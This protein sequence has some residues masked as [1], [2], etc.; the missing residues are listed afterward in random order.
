MGRSVLHSRRV[1]PGSGWGVRWMMGWANRLWGEV[2]GMN[3]PLTVLR[4]D[5][6][7]HAKGLYNLHD[8]PRAMIFWF[9]PARVKSI[10]LI[11]PD[12]FFCLPTG[13]NW[14]P[15]R[16]YLALPIQ[17]ACHYP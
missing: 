10:L 2:W 12:E 13:F 15:T 4:S 1:G 11:T 5:K 3:S 14:L 6:P 9:P 7:F 8:V 17:I 16:Y